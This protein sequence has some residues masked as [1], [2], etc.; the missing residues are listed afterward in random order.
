MTD[1]LNPIGRLNRII[2]QSSVNR[3]IHFTGI[4][5]IGVLV[6]RI[7]PMLPFQMKPEGVVVLIQRA[8]A[9]I[10]LLLG[11][12]V[13]L[14]MPVLLTLRGVMFAPVLYEAVSVKNYCIPG[15]LSACGAC[16]TPVLMVKSI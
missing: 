2:G 5:E 9:L 12:G 3:S 11:S 4:P 10:T 6:C 7:F 14:S 8:K 1:Y 16:T 13:V 15:V